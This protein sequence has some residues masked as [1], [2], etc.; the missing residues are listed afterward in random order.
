MEALVFIFVIL[1]V[2]SV[3][4][5][6]VDTQK[7]IYYANISWSRDYFL[8]WIFYL[9]PKLSDDTIGIESISRMSEHRPLLSNRPKMHLRTELCSYNQCL[10]PHRPVLQKLSPDVHKDWILSMLRED[11]ISILWQKRQKWSNDSEVPP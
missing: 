6:K 9:G 5:K 3:Y 4:Q 8:I 11:V 1:H 2:Y 7:K 10:M